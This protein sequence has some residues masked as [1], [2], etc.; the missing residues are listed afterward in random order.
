MRLEQ[1]LFWD[2]VL[3][4]EWCDEFVKNVLD[5]YNAQEPKL[6]L[7]NENQDPDHNFRM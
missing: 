4:E 3:S 5:I 1:W 6:M 7:S 2:S